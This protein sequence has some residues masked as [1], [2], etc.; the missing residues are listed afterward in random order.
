[1][2]DIK[3]K[4]IRVFSKRSFIDYMGQLGL[5]DSN[6]DEINPDISI[7]SIEV[8][9]EGRDLEEDWDFRRDHY[10]EHPHLN[11]LNLEFY[12]ISTESPGSFTPELAKQI[13]EFL[14][15]RIFLDHSDQLVIHCAAGKSRSYAIGEVIYEYLTQFL[16]YS[17]IIFPE[18]RLPTKFPNPLVRSELMRLYCWSDLQE[19]RPTIT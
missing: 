14:D 12:D 2:E 3:L 16:G 13:K 4:T 15:K 17:E 11:V 10:F 9:S 8:P 1:M 19:N 7:I 18:Y 5:D 6:I